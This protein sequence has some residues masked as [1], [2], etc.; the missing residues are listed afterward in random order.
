MLR[1]SCDGYSSW[2]ATHDMMAATCIFAKSVLVSVL[3][4]DSRHTCAELQEAMVLQVVHGKANLRPHKESPELF[5][6]L[7][8]GCVIL[9]RE[10]PNKIRPV[11]F[12]ATKAGTTEALHDDALH[13][14]HALEDGINLVSWF[15]NGI[16]RTKASCEMCFI[17][18]AGRRK[19][20]RWTLGR[21]DGSI[22]LN[23]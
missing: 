15:Q 10:I 17:H 5:N 2:T 6:F 19:G 11:C 13:S 12:P 21:H 8:G 7:G 3:D 14:A 1:C 16:R 20:R 23:P 9:V 18:S 22:P 4:C